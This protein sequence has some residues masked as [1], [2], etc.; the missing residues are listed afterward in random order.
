MEWTNK[1]YLSFNVLFFLLF[2]ISEWIVQMCSAK[3]FCKNF[4]N[5]TRKQLC[6][7]LRD[8]IPDLFLWILRKFELIFLKTTCKKLRLCLAHLWCQFQADQFVCRVVCGVRLQLLFLQDPVL[9]VGQN[10]GTKQPVNSRKQDTL[11]LGSR[12]CWEP[13]ARDY[14]KTPFSWALQST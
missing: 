11:Q 13:P 14:R 4:T 10:H 3:S 12:R 6:W 9:G 8:T 7:S 2:H 1:F 5:L